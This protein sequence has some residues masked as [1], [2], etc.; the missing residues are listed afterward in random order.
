M[1]DPEQSGLLNTCP[2]CGEILDVSPYGPYEKVA[3]PVCETAMRVRRHF[4][5]FAIEKELGEG[6]MS[7]VFRARD[8]TLGRAVALK[9]LH[10]NFTANAELT[11][12]F[13]REAHLTASISHPNVVKVYSVGT[14]QGYFYIAMELVEGE[15][16]EDSIEREGKL[17]EGALLD[18]AAQVAQGLRAAYLTGLIHRDIKPG[19]ILMTRGGV[20]KIVDFG[21]ALVSGKDVDESSVIWATPYYAPP[22][23]LYE[24]PEDARSDIYSL[25]ATLFHALAGHPPFDADTSSLQ[26]LREMKENP[27]SLADASPEVSARTAAVV[28]RMLQRN[29]EDRHAN[30]DALIND[31][32]KARASLGEHAA[33]SIAGLF[34]KRVVALA[35]TVFI[36]VAGFLVYEG[37]HGEKDGEPVSRGQPP[38]EDFLVPETGGGSVAA[39]AKFIEARELLLTG[40]TAEAA[41]M[42]GEL[43]G[44]NRMSQPTLNWAVYNAGICALLSGDA[45]RARALFEKLWRGGMYTEDAGE[46][47]AAAFFVEVSRHMQRELPVMETELDPGKAEGVQAMAWLAY[48]LKNWQD[49]RFDEA[50]TFFEAFRASEPPKRLEWI[51]SYKSLLGD[52]EHD[53]KLVSQMPRPRSAMSCD[54]LEAALQAFSKLEIEL[55]AKG[56]APELLRD[57]QARARFL[58]E[59]RVAERKAEEAALLAMAEAEAA[60]VRAQ[61][62]IVVE[63]LIVSLMPLGSDHRF[64]EAIRKLEEARFSDAAATEVRNDELRAWKGA[65]KFRETLI[66]E[67]NR[68]GYR[69]EIHR[70]EGSPLHGAIPSADAEAVRVRLEFGETTIPFASLSDHGLLQI[71]TGVVSAMAE[72]RERNA[73]TEMLVFYARQTGDS[74]FARMVGDAFAKEDEEFAKIWERLFR[75]AGEGE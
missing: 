75:V 16:L 45:S 65:A 7:R 34:S 43:I 55:R 26:E 69:G 28:D 39:A 74:V 53:A 57:R 18:I 68:H 36:F 1:Q 41:A 8:T 51:N 48:G 37:V 5:H 17:E 23:K 38:L 31:L 50:V 22:E 59:Q 42:F 40:R 66:R 24:E 4:D 49:G 73:L 3:C 20:A 44:D 15:S 64:E 30:Y 67:L 29:P 2:E 25:G 54:E 56:S 58:H 60:R 72:G 46:R 62:K 33:E 19:N 70:K 12:R 35:A 11:S 32:N 13:E 63:K 14:D 10:K 21:L 9:I 52:F 61:E 47:E 27:V 6:G 71:G